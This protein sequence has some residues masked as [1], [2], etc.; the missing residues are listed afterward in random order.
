MYWAV[1]WQP[2]IHLQ[3]S[4]FEKILLKFLI[5]LLTL[6]LAPF[7]PKLVSHSRNS[8]YLNYVRK[9]KNH[10]KLTVPRIYRI[11]DQFARKR[12]Q[13]KRKDVEYKLPPKS[14]MHRDIVNT[15]LRW[16]SEIISIRKGISHFV[17]GLWDWWI[18][19]SR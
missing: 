3:Q 12:C 15:F 7:A 11:I 9:S 16:F 19:E 14:S 5:H 17:V 4:I 18:I 1:F 8:E 6:L 10:L 13:K 2:T